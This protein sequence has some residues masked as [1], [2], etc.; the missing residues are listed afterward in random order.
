MPSR[1][2]SSRSERSSC[3]AVVSSRK[4]ANI[5]VEPAMR[6][7]PLQSLSL[8][9]RGPVYHQVRFTYRRQRKGRLDTVRK[10]NHNVLVIRH[11]HDF[12]LWSARQGLRPEPSSMSDEAPPVL[13]PSQWP[14]KAR[15]GDLQHIAR[16][17]HRPGFQE[18]LEGPTDARAVVGRHTVAGSAVRAVH[19]HL[20]DGAIQ[21]SSSPKIDQLE[22]ETS[23]MIANGSEERVDRHRRSRKKNVGELPHID[24]WPEPAP[25]RQH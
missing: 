15:G 10:S 23:Q 16:P 22:A 9:H 1:S 24:S 12:D 2:N 20:Q 6:V 18:S 14:L 11:R 25:P 21:R 8:S 13:R 7:A 4:A 17:D 5:S 3:F 19:P